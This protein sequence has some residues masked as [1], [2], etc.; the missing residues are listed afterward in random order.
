MYY[1]WP[2]PQDPATR[3]KVIRI[4]MKTLVTKH[5]HEESEDEDMEK[6]SLKRVCEHTQNPNYSS[7]HSFTTIKQVP[8]P[9]QGLQDT[10]YL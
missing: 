8:L 9:L 1:P 3:L 7:N 6:Q 10:V 5:R 4:E 2:I